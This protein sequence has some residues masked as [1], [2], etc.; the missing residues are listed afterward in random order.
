MHFLEIATPDRLRHGF[1][2]RVNL[3]LP[4]HA[5]DVFTNC[6]DTYRHLPRGLVVAMSIS[7]KL[8]Q[9]DFLVSQVAPF[10]S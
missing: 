1:G 9:C 10:P 8:E 5:A 6:V 4:V 7:Q 2:L 3:Q